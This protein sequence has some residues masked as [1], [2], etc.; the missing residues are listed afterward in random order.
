LQNH[1]NWFILKGE[2]NF[3]LESQAMSDPAPSYTKEFA[4]SPHHAWLGILTLGAGFISTHPIGLLVG[5]AAYALGWIYLPDMAFF[6]RWVDRRDEARRQAEIQAQ[7]DTFN[8]QRQTLLARLPAEKRERYLA[9]AMVC[10]EIEKTTREKSPLPDEMDTDP[11]LRKLDELMWTYLRL[12]TIEENLCQFIELE[13]REQLPQQVRETELEL[14]RLT[15]EVDRLKAQGKTLD[16]AN[17]RL[18][19]SRLE[20]LEVVRKRQ[21]RFDQAQ[22]NLA[23]VISEQKRL[24]NQIKLVRADSL[25]I[26]NTSSISARIDAT[27]ENLEATNRFITGMD[28]FKDLVGDLPMTDRRVGYSVPTTPQGITQA[29]TAS[30]RPRPSM[31]TGQR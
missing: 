26:N 12:L 11:R 8:R 15:A 7:V 2:V 1:T 10:R 5:A 18:L 16:D 27:V 20:L 9:L 13:K 22:A 3:A 23:L 6:K 14:N 24:D 31:P 28:E 4:R 19:D 21:Q 17:Q 30:Q 29:A 25:A